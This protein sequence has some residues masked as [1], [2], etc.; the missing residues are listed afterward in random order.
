M[1]SLFRKPYERPIPFWIIITFIMFE[2]YIVKYKKRSNII[3][4]G[5]LMS[6]NPPPTI[7]LTKL[8]KSIKVTNKSCVLQA[9]FISYFSSV[10][11]LS[12]SSWHVCLSLLN[13]FVCFICHSVKFLYMFICCCFASLFLCLYLF[14]SL[15]L[16]TYIITIA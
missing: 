9:K 5:E 8:S 6:T 14:V 12:I 4:F 7:N 13:M 15:Y 16:I 1:S 2:K 10:F 11:S 3:K